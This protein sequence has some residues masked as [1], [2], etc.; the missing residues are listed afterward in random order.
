MYGEVFH[1][2][3]VRLAAVPPVN[4]SGDEVCGLCR[5]RMDIKKRNAEDFN[6]KLFGSNNE[7][8]KK[9]GERQTFPFVCEYI[10]Y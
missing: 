8:K 1:Q 3:D 2:P 7:K 5:R 9:E 6:I 10:N 4:Q